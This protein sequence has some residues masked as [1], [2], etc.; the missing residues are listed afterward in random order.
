MSTRN[1]LMGSF[2]W[3]ALAA[4]LWMHAVM[5]DYLAF[6]VAGLGTLAWAAI[7][8]TRHSAVVAALAAVRVI[9]RP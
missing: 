1:V 8:C 5:A 7:Y 6:V 4:D 9:R 3:A 2:L